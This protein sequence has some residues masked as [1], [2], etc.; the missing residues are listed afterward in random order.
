M[1]PAELDDIA[2]AFPLTQMQAGMLFHVLSDPVPGQYIGTLT[3][4]IEGP[5]TQQAAQDAWAK[6]VA[7]HEALRTSFLWD[8]LD[9]P[10]QVVHLESPV[11]FQWLDAG[12][13]TDVADTCRQNS[14]DLAQAPLMQ[15]RIIRESKDRHRLIWAVHH[16]VADGWSAS[17]VLNDLLALLQGDDLQAAPVF[18][19]HAEWLDSLDHDA[20]ED[21]W[22]G[23]FAGYAKPEL[24]PRGDGAG[25]ATETR[26]LEADLL[27]RLTSLARRRN[28]TLSTALQAGFAQAVGQL[29]SSRDVLFGLATSGRSGA[30][31]NIENCVGLF[32][33]TLPVRVELDAPGLLEELEATSLGLRTREHVPQAALARWS[34]TPPGENLVDVVLSLRSLPKIAAQ[35]AFSVSDVSVSTPSNI[36]LVVE[37]D[38][39][40]GAVSALYDRKIFNG[41]QVTAFLTAFDLALRGLENLGFEQAAIDGPKLI[42]PAVDIVSRILDQTAANP[43]ANALKMGDVSLS[44]ADLLS[45]AQSVA[46]FLQ[47]QGVGAGDRVALILPRGPE[48]IVTVLGT[49]LAGAAYVPIDA[50]YP[51]SRIALVLEDCNPAAILR[52]EDLA[53]VDGS[54]R[55]HPVEATPQ[56]PAYVIYTS[57][58]T[59]RPKGVEI[60]RSALAFSQAARDQFYADAPKAFLLMSPFA[61]DSSV[62]GI[63][64]ALTQGATLVISP[65]RAEQDMAGL[66]A[67][68]DAEH[69]T[70]TLMLPSLYAA[71]LEHADPKTLQKLR[72][73]IVAGEVC[74]RDLPAAHAALLSDCWLANEYGPTEATVWATAEL[75]GPREA[76]PMS[77]G[78]PI[79]GTKIYLLNEKGRAIAG[80]GVGE[81]AIASNSL[82]TGY[83]DKPDATAAAFPELN[84]GGGQTCRVYRTG[85][86]GRRR[87]DG[88]IDYLGRGDGQ[89]KIRGHRIEIT[90]VEALI[91]PLVDVHDVA[92]LPVPARAASIEALSDALSRLDMHD[93]E[94]LIAKAHIQTK[95]KT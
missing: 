1:N 19:T 36:P 83:V 24:M 48:M 76:A 93:A 5:L 9:Q 42:G 82:A 85:D 7:R 41:P 6:L 92:V 14:F 89:V 78:K 55:Y 58:S 28:V 20:D 62:V 37:L 52:A 43:H 33:N 29:S 91:A 11:D 73:V 70:H 94:A 63:F 72:L 2:D 51:E 68:I 38:P 81:I 75:N 8:G 86:R 30:M 44:Y 57:G 47:A 53:E 87:A 95:G 84:L 71:L 22:L 13:W 74:P 4:L 49:L 61:F 16:L 26:H 17:V 31:A 56:M 23:Y 90:E 67:L 10:M 3:A 65:E 64:W 77:I 40:S 35:G 34:N 45:D 46:G 79:P 60:S 27:T 21:F 59:G 66:G 15:V 54:D 25:F 32:V 88:R 80:T 12:D 69:V 39:A 18:V 50:S